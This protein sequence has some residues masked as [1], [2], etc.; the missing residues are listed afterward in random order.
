MLEKI[1]GANA[2]LP[3]TKLIELKYAVNVIL[4]GSMPS[5]PSLRQLLLLTPHQVRLN[6]RKMHLRKK[7]IFYLIFS[8]SANV[9]PKSIH[10]CSSSL[11]GAHLTVNDGATISIPAALKRS[12]MVLA[13]PPPQP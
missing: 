12:S 6:A 5:A 1:S 9:L 4:L 13:A 10:F 8:V 7:Y 3:G 11:F 2:L